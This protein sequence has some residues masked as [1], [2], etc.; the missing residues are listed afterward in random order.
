MNKMKTDIDD[1]WYNFMNKNS[2]SDDDDSYDNDNTFDNLI[3]EHQYQE[4]KN[5][6][7]ITNTC[8]CS[9][10]YISTKTKIAYLSQNVDLDLFWNIPIINYSLPKEGVIKKQI[11][12]NSSNLEEVNEITNKLKD[13]ECSEQFII[14]KS[15]E[16]S[17][18]FKDVRRV[19]VGLCKK[20]IL[21]FRS[22]KKSAFYNCFVVI[23]RLL[24]N[25]EYKEYHV[26]V[27][28][29]GKLE[30][31][32]IQV[33]ETFTKILDFMKI[34]ISNIS[35]KIYDINNNYETVLINSN[36]TCGYYINRETLF[37]I[38]KYQYNMETMYDPCSYPGIQCKFYYDPD[39]FIQTGVNSHKDTNTKVSFMIF[40]TGSVLIVG[41]CDELILKEVYNFLKK[42]LYDKYS[43]I[44]QTSCGDTIK[45]IDKIKQKKNKN[46]IKHISISESN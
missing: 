15:H 20:D 41:K 3:N 2:D 40:R 12:I 39:L 30:I 17:N 18:K 33:E 11:K 14:N 9:D 43:D 46:R 6:K 22:K 42:L 35:N 44:K 7:N 26:K 8:K 28:N 29:T 13:E 10:I 23:L 21:V 27:F 19:S 5:T 25:D 24:V 16:N 32:G 34:L 37:D 31:P 4:L 45:P 38:L 36:F 1:E